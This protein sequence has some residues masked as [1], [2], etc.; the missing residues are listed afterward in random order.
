M[1]NP[2]ASVHRGTALKTHLSLT[3]VF[4]FSGFLILT[5][6]SHYSL[7]KFFNQQETVYKT[8]SPALVQINK[9]QN[10]LAQ[11]QGHAWRSLSVKSIERQ[12]Q[13][14]NQMKKSLKD[15]NLSLDSYK[16][17]S[18][19]TVAAPHIEKIQTEFKTYQAHLESLINHIQLNT[20]ESHLQAK[21]LLETGFYVSNVALEKLAHNSALALEKEELNLIASLE[22]EKSATLQL[23]MISIA[24]IVVFLLVGMYALLKKIQKT[25]TP[26]IENL[27]Q[28]SKTIA[29]NL[30]NLQAT[31]RDI[32]SAATSTAA[33]LQETAASLEELSSMVKMN[34]DNARQAANLSLATTKSAE[35]G[36]V[37]MSQLIHSI[38]NISE[39]SKKIEDII[40]VIDDIAFQTN[41]L[42]LNASVE[43]AR[44]G[45]QGRGF[46]VVA[47]AVRALSQRSAASAKDIETLIK[48]SVEQIEQGRR[49]ADHSSSVF[50]EIVLSI[51]KVSDLNTEISTASDEQAAGLSQLN[52][53]MNQIDSA[54]QANASATE[55]LVSTTESMANLAEQSLGSLSELDCFFSIHQQEVAHAISKTDSVKGPARHVTHN[56]APPSRTSAKASTKKSVRE[57]EKRAPTDSKVIPFNA[58]ASAKV[59]PIVAKK[60]VLPKPSEIIPFDDDERAKVGTTDDF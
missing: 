20:P 25:M 12:D 45:E 24:I 48:Q 55:H 7:N 16:L 57:A 43:A 30:H 59:K 18:K 8:T 54:S 21:L 9:I 31:S 40:N 14:L 47:E 53:A 26:T 4:I 23:M 15:T 44:A 38:K 22:S 27:S 51:K 17:L 6:M 19:H 11:I 28:S 52:H 1:S 60:D 35:T 10:N 56:V 5:L 36:E 46:S 37:E 33:S 2:Q 3:T 49:L 42:A 58:K 32:T 34:S 29:D 39:S 13:S 41:L 50:S